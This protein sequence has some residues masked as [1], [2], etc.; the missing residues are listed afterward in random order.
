MYYSQFKA[1]DML[2]SF[3]YPLLVCLCQAGFPFAYANSSLLQMDLPGFRFTTCPCRRWHGSVGKST[4]C[5]PGGL[6]L[7][8]RTHPDTYNNNKLKLLNIE[9]N[10]AIMKHYTK[11]WIYLIR[12]WRLER[13]Q[14]IR[15]DNRRYPLW[16][17]REDTKSGKYVWLQHLCTFHYYVTPKCDQ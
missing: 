9:T 14:Q 10:D 8:P 15:G 17:I 4:F 2:F 6:H 3:K 11:K 13:S 5:T 7:V 12:T 16:R 1:S